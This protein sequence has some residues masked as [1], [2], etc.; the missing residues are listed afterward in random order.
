VF[1]GDVSGGALALVVRVA[2]ADGTAP[3]SCVA[4]GA[5]VTHPEISMTVATNGSQLRRTRPPRMT[6]RPF[7]RVQL[8]MAE[9]EA[10]S[11]V[12]EC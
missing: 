8:A 1:A 7:S 2:T 4:V 11:H 3:A 9:A 5:T 10:Q 6:V 12:T